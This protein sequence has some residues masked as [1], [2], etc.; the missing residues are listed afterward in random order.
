MTQR[1]LT[2]A[3]LAVMVVATVGAAAGWCQD[4]PTLPISS[5]DDAAA[6]RGG[7]AVAQ[8]RV[9]GAGSIRWRLAEPKALVTDQMP[10]DW[11]AYNALVFDLYSEKATGSPVWL[12]L[13][14]ED[15]AQ[16]GPDYYSLRFKL[17]FERW[18]HFILP[19]SEIGSVRHPV[20]W[21]SIERFTLHSAWDPSVEVNPEAVVCLDNVRLEQYGDLGPRM[22][23]RELFEALDLDYPGL[24]EVK[25]AVETGDLPAAKTAWARHLR[26]RESPRWFEDWRNRPAPNPRASTGSADLAMENKFRWQSRT[27]DLGEDIDWSQNQ[28][29]EGESATIEWNASLNRHGMFS[30]LARAY[31]D[32]G[33]EKYA[34]KL[35]D[36]MTDWI[37]DAPVL[38]VASGN[39]PYHW[40][41]ETLNTAVRASSAWPESVFLTLD[42]PAWTDDAIAMVTKSFAE[43]ARHL[44]KNPT[45][46]NWL[47]AESTGLSYIGVL[48][49]ELRESEDWRTTAVQRLYEQMD[50]EVY[51]DGPEDE[52]ALGYGMW[53][54]RNYGSVLDF[55]ILN[56]R[57]DEMPQDWLAK[58]ESMYNYVLQITMP[59]FIAP[60]LNDSGNT[61]AAPILEKGF[62]YF[63]QRSDFEW[64]ATKGA[65][66]ELPES[67]S[68][69]LPYCGHYV[70]RS[71]WGPDDLYMLLDAGPFG[72]GHQHEDKLSFVLYAYGRTHIVDGGSYMYDKSR[73]RRYVLSTRGHNT[74]M[75]D[76]LDQRRRKLRDTWTLPLPFEPLDNPWVGE[77]DFN[78]VQGVYDSGYGYDEDVRVS[79]TRS[80]LFVKPEYW[81]IVDRMQPQDEGPHVYESLLHL[82]AD[83]AQVLEGNRVIT[84]AGE[85]ASRLAIVPL[86]TEGLSASVVKGK[87]DEPVQGWSW[88]RMGA[89]GAIPT[90]IYRLEGAG[91]RTMCYLLWPLRPGEELPVVG[92]KPLTSGDGSA[93]AGE[94]TLADGSR[95]LF[96]FGGSGATGFGGFE[97][98]AQVGFAAVTADGAAERSFMVGGSYMR[99]AGQ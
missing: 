4:R 97:T 15:P 92:I 87:E 62:G 29:T 84:D 37:E 75:V 93:V 52:L 85:K 6:W 45:S 96:M 1:P 20:G 90:A 83:Q 32:T 98:D 36:L 64:V 72:S 47:T 73:W 60:G 78:F 88:A 5:C 91:E 50:S 95:H 23:D 94:V 66:G 59:S 7:E 53:V 65:E 10:H 31:R 28:M 40:A 38:L 81:I 42:S 21:N 34:D 63:P 17:D 30:A 67:T 79:H 86:P 11:S 68:Y 19:F 26:A 82:D 33:E 43:H 56:G 39:S 61:S 25:A 80:I 76:G 24:G 9:E 55:A 12:I 57:R 22:T 3:L 99:P 48:F 58:I 74:V 41:W 14:S 16:E 46:R 8:P 69:P 18:R 77:R 71:G 27:F 49:P 54:L 51:P 2:A 44:L 35:V 13:G 89:G 70:M